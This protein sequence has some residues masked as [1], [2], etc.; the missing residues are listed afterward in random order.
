MHVYRSSIQ[1]LYTSMIFNRAK[2]VQNNQLAIDV[3]ASYVEKFEAG[4][5]RWASSVDAELASVS[6]Q[7]RK[8]AID[9]NQMYDRFAMR[10]AAVLSAT[11]KMIEMDLVDLRTE[12]PPPPPTGG[13][14]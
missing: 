12:V 4:D 2:A 1:K 10:D 7:R 9:N 5:S 14:P 11:L 6:D 8:V 3:T 13:K